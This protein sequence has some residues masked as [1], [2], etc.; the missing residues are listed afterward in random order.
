[1]PPKTSF[2]R[3]TPILPIFHGSANTPVNATSLHGRLF[4]YKIED[5]AL[6]KT[7]DEKTPLLFTTHDPLL[8]LAYALRQRVPKMSQVYEFCDPSLLDSE[9][10]ILAYTCNDENGDDATFGNWETPLVVFNVE[11][12]GKTLF[13]NEN[14]VFDTGIRL[15]SEWIIHNEAACSRFAVFHSLHDVAAA[16]V[17][18]YTIDGSSIDLVREPVEAKRDNWKNQEFSC[19]E[20]IRAFGAYYYTF[21]DKKAAEVWTAFSTPS[22]RRDMIEGGTV[23]YINPDLA[24]P[25]PPSSL[26]PDLRVVRRK[27]DHT[28][29]RICALYHAPKP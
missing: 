3:G 19:D 14:N 11:S 9:I 18:I 8:A 24:G 7:A 25:P 28:L 6:I 23:K 12:D 1:M 20:F 15:G 26:A 13:C 2:S 17:H 27:L 16:G 5:N 29:D 22:T 21:D 10:S 4:P